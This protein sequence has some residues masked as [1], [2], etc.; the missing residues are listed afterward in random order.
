MSM[1]R[2]YLCKKIHHGCFRLGRVRA[3]GRILEESDERCGISRAGGDET[4]NPE[5]DRFEEP[6]IAPTIRLNPLDTIR[7]GVMVERSADLGLCVGRFDGANSFIGGTAVSYTH[8]TL[9][10]SDLV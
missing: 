9:P 5:T 7:H 6:Q 10:T 4:V 2:P 1:H 8:L 3:Q